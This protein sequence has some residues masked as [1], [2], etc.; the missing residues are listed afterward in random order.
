M[1]AE[2]SH[3]W[4]RS[5]ASLIAWAVDTYFRDARSMLDVGC[6]VGGVLRAVGRRH[7]GMKLVGGELLCRGLRVARER[8]PDAEFLQMDARRIPFDREFDIVGAFDVIEHID[9]DRTALAQMYQSLVPGGGLLVTVPQHRWLWS[10]FDEASGHRRR[11]T[12]RD[13]SQK[14][15]ETGFALV[16]MTSFMSLTL[17]AI[18]V[19]RIG[20]RAVDLRRALTIAPSVN[21]MMSRLSGIERAVI[22]AGASF[23][24]GG[25]LLAVAV[26]P[27]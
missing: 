14:L 7:T 25:S 26:R 20:G 18:V 19:S 24:A 5:R 4:F 13:L 1:D 9:D 8:L 11:Y 22:R 2:R 10:A 16:R 6:G 15:R 3:F 17:P 23:P 27:R 21:W 12:H